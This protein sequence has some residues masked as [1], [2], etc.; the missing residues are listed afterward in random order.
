MRGIAKVI[1]VGVLLAACAGLERKAALI[2]M[3]MPKNEVLKILGEPGQKSFQGSRE[4]WQYC[5]TGL[6]ADH[7]TTV[8]FG[9]GKT[10]G[11]T[12]EN[13][14]GSIF[15]IFGTIFSFGLCSIDFPAVDW[16]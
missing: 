14:G 4:A 10:E 12:K 13:S 8:F 11:I 1:C 9:D 6:L 15:S 2:E 5:Q 7:Y 3:G 16:G